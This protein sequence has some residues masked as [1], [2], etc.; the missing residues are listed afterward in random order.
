MLPVVDG[1][2][3]V[4]LAQ[5]GEPLTRTAG[6]WLYRLPE[7]LACSER[8]CVLENDKNTKQDRASGEGY[9]EACLFV[10]THEHIY[11]Y[12]YIYVYVYV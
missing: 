9:T 8:F 5:S 12:I 10:H 3:T 11:I 4:G 6:Y 2:R 1:N 7:R